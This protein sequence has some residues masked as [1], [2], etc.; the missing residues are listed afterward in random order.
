MCNHMNLDINA[1]LYADDGAVWKRGTNVNQGAAQIVESGHITG[2]SRA[3]WLNQLY[4]IYTKE[5]TKKHSS[6]PTGTTFRENLN[7]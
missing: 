1:A 7:I 6:G 4:V 2:V 5:S 3:Q